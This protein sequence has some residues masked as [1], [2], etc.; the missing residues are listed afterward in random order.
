MHNHIRS[1]AQ[2]VDELTKAALLIK[3]YNYMSFRIIN[4]CGGGQ[5]ESMSRWKDKEKTM[6]EEEQK[7]G[8]VR[9]K[10][11]QAAPTEL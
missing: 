10:M 5:A 6:R 9:Q 7:D 11:G 3:S 1:V 4:H 2:Q 8:R